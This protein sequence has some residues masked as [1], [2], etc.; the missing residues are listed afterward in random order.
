VV[1]KFSRQ[2]RKKALAPIRT[3]SSHMVLE[4]QALPS[5]RSEREAEQLGQDLARDM[6]SDFWDDT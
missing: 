4:D 1:I 3:A 2:A 6:P 5:E